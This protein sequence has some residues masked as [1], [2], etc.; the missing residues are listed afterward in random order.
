MSAARC[1]GERDPACLAAMGIS[2]IPWRPALPVHGRGP[3][4]KDR[5]PVVVAVGGTQAAVLRLV[6]KTRPSLLAGTRH[7]RA[8]AARPFP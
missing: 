1:A 6:P 5:A 4:G 7:R 3:Q 2:A 8:W